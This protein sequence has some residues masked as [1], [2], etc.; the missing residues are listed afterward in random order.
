MKVL[1]DAQL[2]RRLS[3]WISESGVDSRHT[4]DLPNANQTTDNELCEIAL[5]ENRVIVTKDMDFVHSFLLSGSPS[6]PLLVS[7]GNI[8]NVELLKL[9]DANLDIVKEQ[10]EQG[11]KFVELGVSAVI[12]HS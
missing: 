3:L 2:P 6:R 5:K 8:N 1:V 11:A 4:L 7:T 10:F 12:L 9:F